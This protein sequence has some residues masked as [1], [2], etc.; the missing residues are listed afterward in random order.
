M[1]YLSK[2]IYKLKFY[3]LSFSAN[4]AF[5]FNSDLLGK[6][7]CSIYA[8]LTLFQPLGYKTMRRSKTK[9]RSCVVR[10]LKL[11]LCTLKKLLIRFQRNSKERKYEFNCVMKTLELQLLGK[12]PGVFFTLNSPA[13]VTSR[14]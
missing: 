9:K 4:K 12:S 6:A 2:T 10:L 13:F 7:T 5:T 11:K 3:K 1:M 8:H 14:G